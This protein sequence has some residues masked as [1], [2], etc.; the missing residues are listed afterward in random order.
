[1][2]ANSA[3]TVLRSPSIVSE[4]CRSDA[5]RP[6][7]AASA[8][9]A[10]RPFAP[11]GVPSALPQSAQNF[12]PDALSELLVEQRLCGRQVGGSEAV[13]EPAE[14]LGEHRARCVAAA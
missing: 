1:M 13:G 8:A 2:S 12:P 7:P 10:L 9:D 11:T 3:V 6:L 4:V 14:D 5:M